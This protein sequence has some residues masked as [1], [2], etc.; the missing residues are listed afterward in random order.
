M[1]RLLIYIASVF[2]SIFL[3]NCS[4][5]DNKIT[6]PEVNNQYLLIS[7]FENGLNGW[8][9]PGPPYVKIVSDPA[10]GGGELSVLLK[11]EY[12]GGTINTSIPLPEEKNIYRFSFWAK[13]G[14]GSAKASLYFKSNSE[15][16]FSKR[17]FIS[18]TAWS[19]YVLEDTLNSVSGD[20]LQIIFTGSNSEIGLNKTWVDL[21]LLEKIN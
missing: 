3:I 2:I 15:T 16:K 18:D 21:C 8:D 19:K 13:I 17:I 9:S 10:P 1:K 5:L 11:S 20:S 14:K 12:F 4:E 7:S 6:S